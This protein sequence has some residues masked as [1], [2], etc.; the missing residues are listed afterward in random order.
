MPVA[1][2][3]IHTVPRSYEADGVQNGAALA[4]EIR[5]T[6]QVHENQTR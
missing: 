3:F 2:R 5:L 6:Q 4:K 1:I